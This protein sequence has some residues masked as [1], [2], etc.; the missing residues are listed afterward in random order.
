MRS[1]VVHRSPVPAD[2]DLMPIAAPLSSWTLTG[3]A[4]ID[5]G[6][7]VLP[8]PGARAD[9]PDIRVDEAYTGQW[10]C[11]FQGAAS[12]AQRSAFFYDH[13]R[14]P[15][16]NRIGFTT[17]GYGTAG[18][19]VGGWY[20]PSPGVILGDG[21]VWLRLRCN[22]TATARGASRYRIGSLSLTPPPASLGFVFGL[23]LGWQ[24]EVRCGTP[25]VGAA[26]C[27]CAVHA[28]IRGLDAGWWGHD[29]RW[30][31][32]SA[33]LECSG[34]NTMG[35]RGPGAQRGGVLRFVDTCR[36]H[37]LRVRQH[38]LLRRV[39]AGHAQLGG[40]HNKRPGR[41]HCGTPRPVGGCAE[42]YRRDGSGDRV[43]AR[44]LRGE[45]G[46]VHAWHPPARPPDNSP[47]L[48]GGAW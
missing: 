21:I 38:V 44:H 11:E 46:V 25:T 28:T 37:L 26:R 31:G 47:P 43:D 24:R 6:E 42:A 33:P 8:G 15:A 13:S 39:P 45:R 2:V 5:V 14:V 41:D 1:T 35:A 27:R 3:G 22:Y 32:H 40:L 20:T 12:S 19:T 30:G 9:S 18:G 17:N 34:H 16:L 23:I 4:W 10:V 36:G 48:T 29:G 7:L